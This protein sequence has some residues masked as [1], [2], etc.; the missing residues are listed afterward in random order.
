MRGE[1]VYLSHMQNRTLV[2]VSTEGNVL[3]HTHIPVSSLIL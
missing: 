2:E 1:D 3:H